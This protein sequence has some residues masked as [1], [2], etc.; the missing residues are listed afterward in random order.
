M[1][2]IVI[3]TYQ[4]C[5]LIILFGNR[6]HVGITKLLQPSLEEFSFNLRRVN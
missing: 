3:F 2:T 1:A 5:A 6:Y 4:H